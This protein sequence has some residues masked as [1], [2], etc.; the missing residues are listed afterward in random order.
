MQQSVGAGSQKEV[1]EL[2]AK[3]IEEIAAFEYM[4]GEVV[5]YRKDYEN[6]HQQMLDCIVK[7]V[8]NV[9]PHIDD[10]KKKH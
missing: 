1:E 10:K 9:N 8:L 3:T 7:A 6:Y 5:R 4:F 2:S